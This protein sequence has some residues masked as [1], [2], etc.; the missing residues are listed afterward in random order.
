MS[1][2]E[3]VCPELPSLAG[4][5]TGSEITVDAMLDDLRQMNDAEVYCLQ[6]ISVEAFIDIFAFMNAGGMVIIAS[7]IALSIKTKSSLPV[8]IVWMSNS[9]ENILTI[10]SL[11][12]ISCNMQ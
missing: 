9:G 11:K 5:I 12:I 10:C 8:S 6:Q 7:I 1:V 3:V 2:N 4:V